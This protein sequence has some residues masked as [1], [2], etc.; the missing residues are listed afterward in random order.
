MIEPRLMALATATPP[1]V[2]DQSQAAAMAAD[3]FK[4]KVFRTPDLLSIF[5]NTGIKTRRAVRPLEWYGQPHDWSERNAVYLDGAQARY[6]EA[7][8]RALT[9]SGLQ[10]RDV[11]S[12]DRAV[13]A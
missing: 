1:H 13:A 2:L 4:G 10:A 9:A 6:V 11:Q 3:V 5:E 7:A 12:S 8:E